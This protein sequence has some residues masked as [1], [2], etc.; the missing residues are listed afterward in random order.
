[1]EKRRADRSAAKLE[2]MGW[3]VIDCNLRGRTMASVTIEIPA[4]SDRQ[5]NQS[6]IP[7]HAPS[8]TVNSDTLF[9]PL[10]T[11]PARIP[12]LNHYVQCDF[13][14][15]S[16]MVSAAQLFQLAVTHHQR[17][18]FGQAERLYRQILEIDPA[19][20]NVHSNLGVALQASGRGAEALP[21]W[22]HAVSRKRIRP[23]CR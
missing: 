10:P 12:S 20:P 21:C 3:S 17:G 6:P 18:D 22:R 4:V 11:H 16:A 14:S 1:M 15:G 23:A 19:Y 8:C 2:K 13:L 9:F 7:T 5:I